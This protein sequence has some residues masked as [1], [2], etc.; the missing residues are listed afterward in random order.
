[1]VCYDREK[2]A[3]EASAIIQAMRTFHANPQLLDEARSDLAATLDR[4]CPSS[5]ARHAVAATLALSAGGV[6]LVPG[7]P[8][9]WSA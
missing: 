1:M 7:T 9:F 5:I 8:T 4:I 3:A 2:D 6:F